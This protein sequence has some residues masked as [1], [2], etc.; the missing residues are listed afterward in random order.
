MLVVVTTVVTGKALYMGL[1]SVKNGRAHTIVVR[2]PLRS[3]SPVVLC[4]ISLCFV[5]G[6][7]LVE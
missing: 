3:P 5:P 2:N 4:R 6:V 1:I 7:A